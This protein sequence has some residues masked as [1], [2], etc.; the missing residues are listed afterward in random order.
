M[1][2]QA[3]RTDLAPLGLN[4]RETPVKT[5]DAH[6]LTAHRSALRNDQRAL[7]KHY[8]GEGAS[9]ALVSDSA[10]TEAVG[11]QSPMWGSVVVGAPPL[12]IALPVG[13]H[14][15]IGGRHDLPVPG[16]ILCAALAACVDS[17]IRIIANNLDLQLQA[18]SVQAEADCDV[19]GTLLVDP[20]ASVG[21]KCMRVQVQATPGPGD[22]SAQLESL[23]E[24]AERC[25]VVLQTLN[26]GVPVTMQLDTVG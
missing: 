21:F 5:L 24:M 20:E 25:C 22:S 3:I 26:R 6:E 23:M 10:S 15:A 2:W 14:H 17:S 9:D 13:V 7:R 16:D 18:L 1:F 4:P 11:E 8:R 12:G 19:R